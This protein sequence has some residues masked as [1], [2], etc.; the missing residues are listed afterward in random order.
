VPLPPRTLVA[1]RG[2]AGRRVDLVIRRHLNDIT[3][4]TRTRV[5]AWIDG[6][7]VSINGSVVTR[8]A[9]RTALG[10]MVIVELP[11]ES[12]RAQVVA[13]PGQLDRLFEDDH[14]VIVKKQA[15]MVSHPT[16][17]HRRGS[18]LNLLLHEAQGWPKGQRPSLVGRLDKHTSGAVVVAK[19]T[20]AHA[21]LQ[22]S[23]ASSRSEKAY[24]AVVYGPVTRERGSINLRLR[25]HA[26]DRRRVVAD[27]NEGLASLTQFER[28]DQADVAGC[29]VALMRCRLATGR[30]HQIRVHM[31]ASGWPIVG[32]QKYGEP[33][34]E[35][36]RDEESRSGLE[37]FPRQALHAWRLSFEHPF[38]H[39]TVEVEAPL[40]SDMRELLTSCG[41]GIRT[42]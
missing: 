28:I 9:T 22:R 23:L 1:D 24:L 15:G 37:A 27:V 20:D 38:T 10:D 21:R 5:Q 35:R 36:S 2:D 33:R 32:D 39:Q 12:P 17:L 41:L 16:Y 13:E 30:M 8:V 6:G 42:A 11:D 31:A 25:R 3:S 40:P 14:L 7:R 4:A 19:T 18:L 26:D 29:E 34:W